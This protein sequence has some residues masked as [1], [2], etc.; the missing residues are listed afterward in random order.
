MNPIVIAGAAGG[1]LNKIRD[2]V[3]FSQKTSGNSSLTDITKSTRVEPLVIVSQDCMNLEY[4]PEVM[5]SSQSLFAGYYL[6]AVS[7]IANVKGVQA[8]KILD[9]LNPNGGGD[10]LKGWFYGAENYKFSLPSI[11]NKK[12]SLESF[13]LEAVAESQGKDNLPMSL[14]GND[15]LTS[16]LNENVNLSIGR[17]F[18]VT[19][20]SD[21]TKLMVPISI[22]LLVN[23]VSEK[24]IL[25]ML[26]MMGRDTTLSERWHNWRSGGIG[27]KDL[28]FANDLIKE[29]KK[30]MQNDK[31]GVISEIFQ[32]SN[33]AKL[34]SFFGSKSLNLAS[35]SNIYVISKEIAD[36]I[37]KRTGGKM[38]NFKTR[39]QML[40]SGYCMILVV[41]DKSW[42]RVTFYHRGISMGTTVGVKDMRAANKGGG[43]DVME[44]MKAYMLGNQP[45]F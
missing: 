9:K 38:S 8:A 12:A 19:L 1:A 15:K 2:L 27:W 25:S 23:S 40:Q 16:T 39:E 6:Q 7:L 4:L 30:M 5:Q 37:E 35:A 14:S 10:P 22:R 24:S 11:K 26:T 21:E 17:M 3:R 20:Q 33:N 43:P 42:E 36:E 34:N 41:I 44:I 32:R 28:I 29:S 31:D 45:S 13:A 18:N